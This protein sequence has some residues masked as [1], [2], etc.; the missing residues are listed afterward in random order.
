MRSVSVLGIGETK[1]GKLPDRSL[2]DLISEAG[3]KAIADAGI[4][5]GAIVRPPQL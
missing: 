5:K 1:F 4:D 2:R 3:N